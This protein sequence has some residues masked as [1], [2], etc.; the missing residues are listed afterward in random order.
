MNSLTPL[1][2]QPCDGVMALR[3]NSSPTYQAF[4]AR[5]QERRVVRDSVREDDLDVVNVANVLIRSTPDDLQIG[6]FAHG[7]AAGAILYAEKRRPV[8]CRHANRL[9]RTESNPDDLFDR[10]VVGESRHAAFVP[11]IGIRTEDEPATCPS[12]CESQP[13]CKLHGGLLRTRRPGFFGHRPLLPLV[14]LSP[15]WMQQLY[16]IGGQRGDS[17]SPA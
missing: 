12:E 15:L 11:T 17:V 3:R 6:F 1:P 14:P 9:Q 10:V 2:V 16:L 7:D 4:D 8:E 13:S 5:Q